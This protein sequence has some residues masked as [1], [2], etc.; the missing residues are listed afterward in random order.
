MVT[1]K[2]AVKTFRE[3]LSLVA[4]TIRLAVA[5]GDRVAGRA[6]SKVSGLSGIV[7]LL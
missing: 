1:A 5:P 4:V 7:K 2:V 6:A 3:A